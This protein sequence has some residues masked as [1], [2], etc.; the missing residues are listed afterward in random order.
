MGS[1]IRIGFSMHPRWARAEELEA[2][3]A[4][5]CRSGLSSL[6]FELD[7][8]QENW[9][10]FAPLMEAA[11]QMGLGLSFHAPYRPPYRLAGF[12]GQEHSRIQDDYRPALAIAETWAR[13]SSVCR[14]VVIHAA[15]AKEPAARKPLIEDTLAFL[16]W[17]LE[18][19]PDLQLALE[20][21]HPARPGEV[22]VGVEPEDVLSMLTALDTPRLGACWDLGHDYLRQ[23]GT[24]PTQEWLSRV[25]HIHVHD[26]DENGEDHFPLIFGRVPYEHWLGAW[27]AVTKGGGVVLELKGKHLQNWSQS[28]I[29]EALET[30]ISS[31]N[32]VLA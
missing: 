23:K 30:S 13:R 32:K 9:P 20:N 8:R 24:V 21:N 19:F 28:Q 22:K 27:K 10:D 15:V 14:T 17:V 29:A 25:V 31:L 1:E 4:P 6:E 3:I 11:F 5:M 16:A 12:A 7:D 2:F 18:E 26:V